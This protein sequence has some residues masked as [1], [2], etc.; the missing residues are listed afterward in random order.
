M[1]VVPTT[2]GPDML[3]QTLNT[4]LQDQNVRAAIVA[5]GAFLGSNLIQCAG[6]VLKQ[7]NLLGNLSTEAYNFITAAKEH[8]TS[9]ERC[10]L[11]KAIA[12]SI[13]K[14]T[15]NINRGVELQEME[16]INR[17]LQD[18]RPEVQ[19][20]I[21]AEANKLEEIPEDFW[22]LDKWERYQ[23]RKGK[24]EVT[25]YFTRE[26]EGETIIVSRRNFKID[27]DMEEFVAEEGGFEEYM[28]TEREGRKYLIPGESP[29]KILTLKDT[30][31]DG[32]P[33]QN[34]E[35]YLQ[36]GSSKIHLG[37]LEHV[38]QKDAIRYEIAETRVIHRN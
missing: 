21:D 28:R 35:V 32:Q 33:L 9:S 17:T 34:S 20:K 5:G 26:Y 38:I 6:S 2:G 1:E 14:S 18:F 8:V 31:M 15:E 19:A 3:L 16:Q 25:R 12:R 13:Q 36:D 7:N 29:I 24:N 23:V 22:D 30:G 37:N 27:K 4:A 11:P 10:A